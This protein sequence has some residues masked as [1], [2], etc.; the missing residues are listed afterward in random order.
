MTVV[1]AVFILPET[2][3][4][5]WGDDIPD[6][7]VEFLKTH[8]DWLQKADILPVIGHMVGWGITKGLFFLVGILEGLVPQALDLK[9]FLESA[10]ISSLATAVINDLVLALM[11]LTIVI[12]GIKTIVAKEPPKFKNVAVNV[13][14]SG[15][16]IVGLPSL[17]NTMQDMAIDFYNGTQLS[18]EGEVESLSWGLIK[19]N[20]ADLLYT[21]R[22]DVGFGVIANGADEDG[23][24][25]KNTLTKGTFQDVNMNEV[26]TADA[27][28]E[29][30][31]S[32][33]EPLKYQLA[34]DENNQYTAVE[35]DGNFLSFFSS[36]FDP[37]Y[38]RFSVK[39]MP[40]LVGLLALGIAYIF[41]IFTFISTIIEI[42]VK[43]V[44]GLFIFATDLESGQR[45]KMVVNDLMNAYLL[46]AFTGLSLR[47]YTIFLGYLSTQQP[48][49]F[50]YIIAIVSATFI[51]IKGS[52]TIMRYFGVDVGLKEGYGQLAGA[53]ALG[54]GLASAGRNMKNTAK[55]R[56][57][58]R[59]NGDSDE[60]NLSI[61][62]KVKGAVSNLG[63]TAGYMKNRGIKG[64]M[65]DSVSAP[66]AAAGAG[67]KGY[68]DSLKD[69]YA[70]GTEKAATN[71]KKFD[72]KDKTNSINNGEV[73]N[74]GKVERSN[75]FNDSAST[76]T[77]PESME[78]EINQS[79]NKSINGDP[80]AATQ[81]L[82]RETKNINDSQPLNGKQQ[83]DRELKDI[84][85]SESLND[86]Q[87]INREV[88]TINEPDSDTSRQQLDREFRNINDSQPMSEKQQLDREYRNI[89]DS[90]PTADNQHL[91]REVRNVNAD[92]IQG[93]NQNSP[94][95]RQV[96]EELRASQSQNNPVSRQVT[97]DLVGTT[98][99]SNNPVTRQVLEEL[100]GA[101]TS[102]SSTVNRQVVEELKASQSQNNPVSRQV[103]EEVKGT[104]ASTNN[105][106]TRQIIE[107]LR[108]A[109]TSQSAPITR[110]VTQ[111]AIQKVIQDVQKIN[112]EN[113]A[114]TQQVVE[115]I[116]GSTI[117]S[118][119]Q[120]QRIIQE[121][122][123]SGNVTPDQMT[124]NVQQVLNT[125]GSSLPN[126]TKDTVQKVIQ[127]VQKGSAYNPEEVKTKVVEEI[128]RSNHTSEPVRQ[129][130]IQEVQKAFSATPEQLEQNIKQVI[131]TEAT[132]D[133]TNNVSEEAS[134]RV[135]QEVEETVNEVTNQQ[136]NKKTSYFG[137]M[138]SDD[139]LEPQAELP[140]RKGKRFKAFKNV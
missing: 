57:S 10:G 95:N 32:N 42:G 60:D 30:D 79:T 100:R 8:S 97:E 69:G 98:A 52:S 94:I 117:G 33:L 36:G 109:E 66:I 49:I 51:L 86:K 85:D 3:L 41:A 46:I 105:P 78:Q 111:E 61:N 14:V 55:S 38:F 5:W 54:K 13:V 102:Q 108:G 96:T 128:Q 124:Q 34:V 77:K 65:K 62:D 18:S 76:S 81:Q 45:T 25:T 99:N 138:F 82:N 44:V 73:D 39:F 132:N 72:G 90:Q 125:V 123:K 101:E 63:Q 43:R 83:Q 131:Q 120:K 136:V 70:Q 50:I 89:N 21:A 17:M 122:I 59:S 114:A 64:M 48:N 74:N 88:R 58:G 130:V 118:S 68:S 35:M 6:G 106:V 140:V 4:A 26:L 139:L 37:G 137:K 135:R 127:E 91:N 103:T 93:T 129:K 92:S 24:Q 11:I 113:P 22:S 12:L 126:D 119:E 31:N 107:E 27:I 40:I 84:S 23:V 53:F 134:R 67:V 20:T 71:S 115:Q 47:F 16:L 112:F 56:K 19:D 80:E 1:L 133:I 28:E 15:I 110:Q 9:S 7:T 2:V 29:T 121:V 87:Q 75:D 104:A 116:N